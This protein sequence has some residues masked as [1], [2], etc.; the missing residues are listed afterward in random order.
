M[1]KIK[2][3]VYMRMSTDKQEHSIESQWRL[4]QQYASRNQY[5]IVRRYEDEGISG[6]TAE[7]RPAFLQMVEDSSAKEF[8]AVLIYDSSRFAR[9]LKDAVVYKALLRQNG[10]ELISITE[11]VLDDDTSLITDALTG[12]MNEMYSRKL[13]KNVKRGLEQKAMRG[14]CLT[15]PPFGYCKPAPKLPFAVL[16]EEAEIV[17]YIFRVY[18]QPERTAYNIAIELSAKGIKTKNGNIF[19]SRQVNRILTNPAYKGYLHAN[20]NGSDYLKKA[21]FPALISEEEFDLVQQLYEQRRITRNWHQKPREAHKHWLSGKIWCG[22]CGDRYYCSPGYQGRS[23]NWRCCNRSRGACHTSAI[24]AVP[25]VEEMFFQALEE[26]VFR[27]DAQDEGFFSAVLVA[28]PARS[29]ENRMDFDSEEKKL[30]A[31]LKR[32]KEAYLNGI[33]DLN[34]YRE[35]RR[36]IQAKL[37]KLQEQKEKESRKTTTYNYIE[38]R[39]RFAD[40]LNL[41]RSDAT[42]QAKQLIIEQLLDRIVIDSQNRVITPFFYF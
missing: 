31:A 33:D 2:A 25:K 42:L 14:E 22:I 35:N 6:R 12:A 34:E 20:I 23:N 3:A 7:K 18:Q 27:A 38:L 16:P 11:P 21:D 4:I 37:E 32:A 40:S 19:D 36:A 28:S 5:Q 10:V 15:R 17:R 39:Q 24:I 26:C 13:S 9:N 1:S 30:M 8:E 41:L 29:L